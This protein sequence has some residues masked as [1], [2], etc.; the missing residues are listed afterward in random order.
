MN[1]PDTDRVEFPADDPT[2]GVSEL[3]SRL[4]GVRPRPS[5]FTAAELLDAAAGATSHQQLGAADRPAATGRRGTANWRWSVA[6]AASW[7]IGMIMGAAGLH[8]VQ[9]RDAA[10]DIASDSEQR[11]AGRDAAGEIAVSPQQAEATDAQRFNDHN[12]PPRQPA[13][14]SGTDERFERILADWLD[15]WRPSGIAAGGQ[16]LRS[17]NIRRAT[18]P[19]TS[20]RQQLPAPDVDR[21]GTPPP[22]A[23][24]WN[25]EDAVPLTPAL[26]RGRRRHLVDDPHADL[27]SFNPQK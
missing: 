21:A 1:T 24:R 25:A 26:H 15:P 9:G 22:P 18:A 5:E 20:P 4:R 27:L 23:S 17:L 8:I 3:E 14:R 19:V 6:L 12:D 7:M 2:G 16:S 13:K 11:A 10:V